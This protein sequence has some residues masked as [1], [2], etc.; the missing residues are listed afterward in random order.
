[1]PKLALP[2]ATF[3]ATV[4]LYFHWVFFP[5]PVRAARH[6]V[7]QGRLLARAFPHLGLEDERVQ[8]GLEGLT[9]S[10]R[11]LDQRTLS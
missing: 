6:L 7:P 8:D 3:S 1:M 2:S 10:V 5:R 11:R 9:G 4:V